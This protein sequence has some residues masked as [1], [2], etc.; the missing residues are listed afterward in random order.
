MGVALESPGKA[1][2]TATLLCVAVT[3]GLTCGG[4][5]VA[6]AQ[7]A[8]VMVPGFWDPKRRPERPDV[9]R[10]GSIRFLTEDNYP[11]FNFRGPGGQ[12]IG[13]NV[14]LARAICVELALT[15]TVQ[16]R[17]FDTLLSA[18]EENR[19]DAIVASLA[20]TPEM[21]ARVAFS[22]RYYRTP[23]RFVAEK[24]FPADDMT[25]ER[26]VG[27]RVAVVAGS[28]HEAYLRAFFAETAIQSHPN[29]EASLASLK[30][31]E[32]DLVF[33]DGIALSFWLNGTGSEK[34]CEFRGG[35]F[36]ESRYFGEGIGIAVKRDNDFLRRALNYALF[37]LWERGI[38]A[39]L[40]LRYFPIGF[41]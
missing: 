33:A 37:R 25:P 14:D 21:R 27:R 8:G 39:D 7:S 12:P 22:D 29:L 9:S 24:S 28:A 38:I 2:V 15:C 30:R 17:R 13:L 16:V 31:G 40:Y 26:I 41:Y 4:P 34:C 3:L 10:L 6:T 5:Q 19:G 1:R 11:P 32:A 18:L 36:T 20:I 35:P 23:A